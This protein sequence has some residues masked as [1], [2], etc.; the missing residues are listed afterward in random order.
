MWTSCAAGLG[1][2][3]QRRLHGGGAGRGERDVPAAVAERADDAVVDHEP[4]L[5]QQHRVAEAAGLEIAHTARVE[6]LEERRRVRAGDEELAERADVHHAD[7]LAHRPVLG[8]RR[9]RSGSGRRQAPA[10]SIVASRARWRSCSAVCSMHL[11]AHAR[12]GLLSVIPRVGGRPVGRC[13]DRSPPGGRRRRRARGG[14]TAPLARPHR[15]GRVALE[16]LRGAKALLPGLR[17][18]RSRSRPRTGRRSRAGRP[19]DRHG[20][21]DVARLLSN[22]R[23]GARLRPRRGSSPGKRPRRLRRPADRPWRSRESR[24]SRPRESTSASQRRPSGRADDRLDFPAPLDPLD[25]SRAE[26]VTV[27]TEARRPVRSPTSVLVADRNDVRRRRASRA[28]SRAVRRR[29]RARRP[30]G[31]SRQRPVPSTAPVATTTGAD[32]PG[33]GRPEL[34]P[35]PAALRRFRSPRLLEQRDR[36]A[37]ADLALERSRAGA[38]SPGAD[39]LRRSAPSSQTTTRSPASAAA[40]A[41][42]RPPHRPDHEHIGMVVNLFTVRPRP[43]EVDR[44]ETCETADHTL[45]SWPGPLRPEQR[46][47]VEADRQQPVEPIVDSEKVTVDTWPA[48]FSPDMHPCLGPRTAG[49]DRRLAV[50]VHKAVRAVAGQAVEPAAAVVLERT[51][52]R[53]HARAEE[54]RSDGVVALDRDRSPLEGQADASSSEAATE[55]LR[56]LRR[57]TAACPPGSPARRVIRPRSVCR[58]RTARG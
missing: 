24:G 20:S 35:E 34:L 29:A 46:L 57:R 43:G 36:G 44:A 53:P 13:R 56:S 27:G 52:E 15:R 26:H 48:A 50:D 14:G 1:P 2:V 4:V 16:D 8:Q 30:V 58:R 5:A 41:A 23:A 10:G 33:E 9:R 49:A 22:R 38:R 55:P 25:R 3:L 17:R 11:V 28:A 37:L 18:A 19:P 21:V 12:R 54:R 31:R 42:A 39:E 47:V 32:G 45:G 6:P 51:R 40:S 7:A